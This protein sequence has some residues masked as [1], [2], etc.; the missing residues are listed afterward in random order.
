MSCPRCATPLEQQPLDTTT[1]RGCPKCGG[2][3]L[4]AAACADVMARKAN[5]AV[6]V[7][8]LVETATSAQP[9]FTPV[10]PCPDCG[11]ALARRR[12]AW[13]DGKFRPVP[14]DHV[15]RAGFFVDLD[16]CAAHGT[17]FDHGEL[18]RLAEA[19]G[20]ASRLRP[21]IEALTKLRQ[22]QAQQASQGVTAS[23]LLSASVT[24]VAALVTFGLADD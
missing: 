24:V 22:E 14:P 18:P 19:I 20:Q 10:G 21:N 23:G 11:A 1:L 4:N 5:Q 9:T 6:E 16:V 3:W 15:S 17:F 13:A 2:I 12:F 7:A 8:K